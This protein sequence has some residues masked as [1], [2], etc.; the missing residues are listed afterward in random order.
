MSLLSSLRVCCRKAE[1]P[2]TSPRGYESPS[3]M[4][5]LDMS[6]KTGI[7]ALN[8][9]AAQLRVLSFADLVAFE[10]R[11]REASRVSLT[12]KAVYGVIQGFSDRL[13]EYCRSSNHSEADYLI[14]SHFA[15][16]VSFVVKM[17]V[18]AERW[19][20]SGL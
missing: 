1:S 13:K 18:R 14:M 6:E 12:N 10:E 2:S 16:Q 5:L 20:L 8:T 11:V 3:R 19:R 9:L 4:S 7:V 15:N 17:S